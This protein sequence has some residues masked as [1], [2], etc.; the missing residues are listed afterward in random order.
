MNIFTK[1]YYLVII[2]SSYIIYLSVSTKL[3]FF[4]FCRIM[5]GFQLPI[6]AFFVFLALL[7]LIANVV[8]SGLLV[9][10]LLMKKKD[11]CKKN[12]KMERKYDNKK[13]E[14]I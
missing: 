7:V 12:R 6:L 9:I 13:L 1:F 3:Y 14:R 2:L 8:V 4:L 11:D 5:T 10:L